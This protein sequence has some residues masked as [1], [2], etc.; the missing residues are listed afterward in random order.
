MENKYII[1][2][3]SEEETSDAELDS[4]KADGWK[5]Q[6]IVNMEEGQRKVLRK[7]VRSKRI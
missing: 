4:I 3:E 2:S 1:D 5:L 6:D 7:G